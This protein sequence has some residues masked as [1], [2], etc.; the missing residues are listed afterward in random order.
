MLPMSHAVS[1]FVVSPLTLPAPPIRLQTSLSL[2]L[3][4]Q[5]PRVEK[6]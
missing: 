1:W 2:E 3:L 4:G 5:T 6:D